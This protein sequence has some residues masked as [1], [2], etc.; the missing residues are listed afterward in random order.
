M[1]IVIIGAFLSSYGI[2]NAYQISS[3]IWWDL[4]SDIELSNSFLI[5]IRVL[6]YIVDVTIIGAY[7][8]KFTEGINPFTMSDFFLYDTVDEILVFRYWVMYPAGKYLYN[9]KVSV[10]LLT[11]SNTLYGANHTQGLWEAELDSLDQV[12]GIRYIEVSHEDTLRFLDVID[13]HKQNK[14]S[15][16]MYM[17][18]SL[19]GSDSLGKVYSFSKRFDPEL[20]LKGY[21]FVP[22]LEY[23]A[24]V[25][26]NHNNGRH[27]L[28]N[29]NL[30]HGNPRY[31]YF[32]KIYE[33]KDHCIPDVITEACKKTKNLNFRYS[34][35]KAKLKEA[36]KSNLKQKNVNEK[37]ENVESIKKELSKNKYYIKSGHQINKAIVNEKELR[38][39]RKLGDMINKIA[40]MYLDSRFSRDIHSFFSA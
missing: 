22:Y 19:S 6:R 7:L 34:D 5:T 32:D 27:A 14:S 10:K 15:E 30:P 31:Q 1:L 17:I 40:Y 3:Y 20:V 11:R 18:V 39:R 38:K 26:L 16:E 25:F 23:G 37:Q 12:R 8:V 28:L 35:A 33:I 2:E 24:E 21:K 4:E 9:L 36:R 29:H 13:Q